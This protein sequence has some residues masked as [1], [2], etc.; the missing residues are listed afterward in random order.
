VPITGNKRRINECALV[1]R[2]ACSAATFHHHAEIYELMK[3]YVT[4]ER[5]L[6]ILQ[7]LAHENTAKALELESLAGLAN[8]ESPWFQLIISDT[9]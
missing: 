8:L 2:M 1:F 6:Q 4:D 5:A 3:R 9:S 7:D